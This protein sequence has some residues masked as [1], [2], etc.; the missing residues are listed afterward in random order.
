MS[1]FFENI[2][3]EQEWD[4]TSQIDVLFTYID[5]QQS[6][7]AFDDHLLAVSGEATVSENFDVFVEQQGWSK[8]T[9]IDVLTAYINHQQ[10]DDVFNDYVLERQ[11]LENEQVS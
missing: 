7:E 3:T 10:S 5:N 9:Q 11:S 2:A 8:A 1:L 6:D 4:Q